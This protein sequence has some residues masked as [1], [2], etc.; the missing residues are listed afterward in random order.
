M[1]LNDIVTAVRRIIQDETVAYRYS[2][3]F[4]LDLC[5]QGLKR[6]QLLRPDLFSYVGTVACVEN[7]V[8][9]SAPSDS[10]RIIECYSIVGGTGLVEADREVLDQTIPTWVNTTAGAAIN[11]MRHVRNPNKFFIYPKAPANQTLTVEYSQVPPTYAGGA[12][13]TLLPDAYVPALIDVV[14][15][16]AESIDNEHVTNGR[17]KMYM[18]LFMS[19]LGATTASLPV[20]DTENA[21]QPLQIEVV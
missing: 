10:L 6:I 3:V 14:V 12:T 1:I 5:N 7:A 21:G 4:L 15:F 20:T 9:Q 11:W 18:D 16:L 19:E 8:I 2:D 17:A 13:V